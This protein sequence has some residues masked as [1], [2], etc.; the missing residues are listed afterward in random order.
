[1]E[2][3]RALRLFS[4]APPA[5]VRLHDERELRSVWAI[6]HPED[7]HNTSIRITPFIGYGGIGNDMRSTALMVAKV[8]HSGSLAVFDREID[9]KGWKWADGDEA[10]NVQ[11]AE[12]AHHRGYKCF[13][14]PLSPCT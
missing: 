12:G 9:G 8:W 5:F 13:F 1:M 14:L 10:C 6:Q 2:H 11:T 3:L 7:C 4:D